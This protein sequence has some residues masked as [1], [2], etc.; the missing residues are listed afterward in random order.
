MTKRSPAFSESVV[1]QQEPRDM[2]DRL[3]ASPLLDYFIFV[4]DV[5]I[6]HDTR[7]SSTDRAKIPR[8]G[9]VVPHARSP[10]TASAARTC[11]LRAR[12]MISDSSI[13][14]YLI[15]MSRF[16][17]RKVNSLCWISL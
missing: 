13:V 6:K 2:F 8:A 5:Q 4:G 14:L 7:T 1:S 11:R 3:S 12:S 16:P 15:D 17:S 9:S 10:G